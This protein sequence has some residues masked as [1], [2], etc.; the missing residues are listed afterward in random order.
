MKGFKSLFFYLT[1]LVI[2]TLTACG[3]V[4]EPE[5]KDVLKALEKE[6]YLTEEQV[7]N[8]ECSVQIDEVDMDDDKESCTVECVVSV[9]DE[10][11]STNT[12]Y[13]IKFKI[14]DDKESWKVKKVTQKETSYELVK[15]IT[16]DDL[17]SFLDGESF[18]ADGSYV[19]FYDEDTEYTV[20][21]HELR[22][23]EMID[24]VT[25]EVSGNAGFKNVIA[26]VKYTLY[27]EYY[28]Y[29]YGYWYSEEREILDVETTYSEEYEIS[30]SE[31]RVIENIIDSNSYVYMSGYYYY[32]ND[33]D[34]KLSN[35]KIG[36]QEYDDY[37]MYVPVTVT[38]S[39]KDT[40]FDVNYN[41]EYYF[42]TYDMEWECN[43]CNVLGYENYSGGI[44]GVWKG[45]SDDGQV[46]LTINNFFHEEMSSCLAAT[47]KVTTTTNE[48]YSYSSYVYYYD[49]STGALD[50][51]GFEW[52]TE[53][54]GNYYKE[55]FNGFCKDGEFK[56]DD[57]WYDFTL[58]KQN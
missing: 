30:L 53:P 34:V 38:V 50:V 33:K 35:V 56:S 36:E 11:V 18:E 57:Y 26:T 12:E 1:L 40:S 3:K 44:V 7:D 21:D 4:P 47:V 2:A 28:G 49:P 54:K 22:G 41:I 58:K 6:G 14:R 43:Y 52:I 29:D 27:Y 10:Y 25:V 13:K 45:T 31:E 42:D 17:D 20:K 39:H 19:Y 32:L 23:D 37:Y 9:E 55:A 46:E 5:E 16:D 48:V 15:S 51:Q 8:D 24:I